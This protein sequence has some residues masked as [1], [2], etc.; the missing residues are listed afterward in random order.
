MPLRATRRR[1]IWCRTGGWISTCITVCCASD[2]QRPG[3]P[4]PAVPV[5]AAVPPLP[6]PS[7]TA[8]D[9]APPRVILG[10][11]RGDPPSYR[12]GESMTLQVQPTRDAFVYCYYQD[13][14]GT[15]VRIFPNRFQPDALLHV[16]TATAIPP[17]GQRAFEIRFDQAGGHEQVACLAADREVGLALPAALKRQDLEPLPLHGLDEVAAQFRALPGARV[18]EARLTIEV[19]R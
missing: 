16:G 18:D 8:P 9:E 17:A 11:G 14:E 19:T 2:N 4:R 15:V 5:A 3:G 12:V 7:P 6:A 13:S 1:M 10:T